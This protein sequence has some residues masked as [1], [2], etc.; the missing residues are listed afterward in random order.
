MP[1]S[2]M[3]RARERYAC[4]WA[5]DDGEGGQRGWIVWQG[6]GAR[7]RRQDGDGEPPLEGIE[8]A[9]DARKDSGLVAF[10]HVVQIG[11]RGQM[12]REDGKVIS[13]AGHGRRR[14]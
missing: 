2:E 11:D 12:K 5:T 4:T 10:D 3:T 6:R 13:D 9:R 1:A 8:A 7:R 14:R